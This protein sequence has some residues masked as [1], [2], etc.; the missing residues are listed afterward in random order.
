[1][2]QFARKLP[3]L[4]GPFRCII[5]WLADEDLDHILLRCEFVRA[6]CNFF[7][8]HLGSYLFGMVTSDMIGGSSFIRLFMRRDASYGW[9]GMCRSSGFLGGSRLTSC[10]GV[11]REVLLRFCL[12]LDMFLFGLWF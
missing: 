11:L 2:D 7:F 1:M 4:V 8:R 12:W 6:A 5:Y 3:L 10:L 9:W